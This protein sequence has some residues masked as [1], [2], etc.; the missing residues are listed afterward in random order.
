MTSAWKPE[1]D[2]FNSHQSYIDNQALFKNEFELL[3]RD[4]PSLTVMEV[5]KFDKIEE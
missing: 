2:E 4:Y 3:Q 5:P 1:S